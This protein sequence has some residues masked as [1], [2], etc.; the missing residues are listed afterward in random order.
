LA[1]A[2]SSEFRLGA[3]VGIADHGSVDGVEKVTAAL[4]EQGIVVFPGFE[5]AS[6]EKVHMVCLYPQGTSIGSLNQNLGAMGLSLG[7]PQDCTFEPVVYRH[8]RPRRQAGR[9][10]VCGS[11]GRRQWHPSA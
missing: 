6:I 11:R 10:L 4:A 8:C 2:T 3:V 7:G 9:I 1:G 5:I